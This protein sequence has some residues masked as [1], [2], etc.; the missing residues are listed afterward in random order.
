MDIKLYYIEGISRIDTPYFSSSQQQ[1]DY[2]YDHLVK[3]ID[4]PYY[5][6][7]YQNSIR[8]DT[9]DV[10]FTSSV[11]YLSLEYGGKVYYY[12]IDS[13]DYSSENVIVLNIT[14]DVIQ[15]YFF[16]IYIAHGVIERKF[17][18]RWIRTNENTPWKINRN[19]IR[20]D[21][22]KA[23]FIPARKNYLSQIY[24]DDMW[25]VYK[26][27]E[28]M[29][30]DINVTYETRFNA[31]FNSVRFTSPFMYL[32]WPIGASSVEYYENDTLIKTLHIYQPG[33]FIRELSPY[34]AD[35]YVVHG[36]PLG[37]NDVYNHNGVVTVKDT[38]LCLPKLYGVS[39]WKVFDYIS[40]LP[41]SS[42]YYGLFTYSY[43]AG[44][45]PNP[46]Q[47]ESVVAVVDTRIHTSN[48][49]PAGNAYFHRNYNITNTFKHYYCPVLLDENY[50]KLEI[51]NDN[52]ITSYPLYKIDYSCSGDIYLMFDY[53]TNP[54]NGFQYYFPYQSYRLVSGNNI[55][56]NS[57]PFYTTIT[58]DTN[59]PYADI[60][61]DS[62]TTWL[63]EN[64]ARIIGNAMTLTNSG[65]NVIGSAVAGTMIGKV[66]D[67]TGTI[68]KINDIRGKT[69]NYDKRYKTPTL[70]KKYADEIKS[71]SNDRMGNYT[72][73]N[74][75]PVNDFGGFVQ[76]GVKMHAEKVQAGMLPNVIRQT[77]NFSDKVNN[78]S[79]ATWYKWSFVNDYDQCGW[80]YHLNGY[81]VDEHIVNIS[82]IFDY[83]NTR[84]Y[85]NVL[86]LNDVDLHLH[87]V[88]ED[89]ETVDIITDVLQDGIRLWNVGISIPGQPVVNF[90]IGDYTYD[91]VEKDYL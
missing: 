78:K 31:Y 53:W 47:K 73:E 24:D 10:S 8:F 17:I 16:N 23:D 74:F 77:A 82:N 57:S 65:I 68:K 44:I 76:Q 29:F 56:D 42:S 1:S 50:I 64:H 5:P 54:I 49:N 18:N 81:R 83:V 26:I 51:G 2:F 75:T 13:V 72:P 85:F 21:N 12:F 27:S 59:I 86:K 67:S 79:Y 7:H 36:F 35:A 9:D 43:E 58:C 87:N 62:D 91:N 69:S 80:F 41:T 32:L 19:Y 3:T 89:E 46:R 66:F 34:I 14:M 39:E 45:W 48:P 38:S 15:T 25:V 90:N 37:N 6:P 20:E 84:Y 63:I 4:L 60:I 71:L 61:V 55:Y 88:I 52:A 40:N 28:R 33:S 22:S 70:K 30:S 11:N